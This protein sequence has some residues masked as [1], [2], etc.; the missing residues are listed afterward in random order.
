MENPQSEMMAAIAESLPLT[1]LA[2]QVK[3]AIEQYLEE[4]TDHNAGFVSFVMQMFLMKRIMKDTNTNAEEMIKDLDKHHK[5][6]DLF[7]ENN[8]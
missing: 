6:M 1:V 5:M 8:N 7:K 3:M 4:P 2:K